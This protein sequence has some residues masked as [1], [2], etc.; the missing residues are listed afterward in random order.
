MKK[1]LSKECNYLHCGGAKGWRRRK[2]IKFLLYLC[3]RCLHL[4]AN[5]EREEMQK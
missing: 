4:I 3:C 5:R 2:M 1:N